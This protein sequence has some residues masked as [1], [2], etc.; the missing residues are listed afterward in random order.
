M[1]KY[2]V[3]PE[4]FDNWFGKNSPDPDYVITEDELNDLARDWECPI[5]ELIDELIE[6]D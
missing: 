6:I 2:I 5:D 1:K 3:D 4:Y